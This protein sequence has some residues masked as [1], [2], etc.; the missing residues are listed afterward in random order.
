MTSDYEG[1][2]MVLV[3]ALALETPVISTNCPSG[4][5]EILIGKYAEWLIPVDDLTSYSERLVELMNKPYLPDPKLVESFERI[6]I[7]KNYLSLINNTSD[8]FRQR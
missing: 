5:G 3:E 8:N 4:P 7:A 1:F 2:G 6:N